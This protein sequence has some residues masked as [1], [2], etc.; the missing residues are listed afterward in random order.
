MITVNGT[1]IGDGA[2]LAEMQYHPASSR[3]E[4]MSE[5]AEALVVLE[6]AAEA[7]E[8][9]RVQH[10]P[11]LE[12][13]EGQ[14]RR[15]VGDLDHLVGAVGPDLGGED[16]E[17]DHVAVGEEIEGVVGGLDHQVREQAA[18][19][20]LVVAVAPETAAARSVRTA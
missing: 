12:R 18:D 20:V 13:V 2:I 5:A 6:L 4:A 15:E 11:A 16:A 19:V 1:E 9:A 7:Q 10:E 17:P 3:D 14:Q 8:V